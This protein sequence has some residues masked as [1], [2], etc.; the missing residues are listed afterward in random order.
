[1]KSTRLTGLAAAAVLTPLVLAGCSGSADAPE[2]G[3]TSGTLT[4][5]MMTGGPGDKPIIEDV[6]AAFE[7]KYPDMDVKVEIQ[8]WDNI[9]TKLTTALASGNGPDIVEMGNTQTPLQTYS[10]GLLDITD[11]RRRSRTPTAGSQDSPIPR[12]WTDVCTPHRSTAAPK[13]SCTTSRC[14]P[15]PGSPS[16]P[17][18]STS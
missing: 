16:S 3:S 10:G 14:S 9:A 17:R 15:M 11:D 7:K 6:N 4:V 5:W 13:W 8:Q 2:A 18:R 1:M 12:R